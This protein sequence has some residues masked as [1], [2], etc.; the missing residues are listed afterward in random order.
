MCV[1]ACQCVLLISSWYA[2]CNTLTDVLVAVLVCLKCEQ[3]LALQSFSYALFR[4]L[5]QGL[6]LQTRALVMGIEHGFGSHENFSGTGVMAKVSY[7]LGLEKFSKSSQALCH[8]RYK[9]LDARKLPL[10]TFC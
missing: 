2:E 6:I 3:E 9:H 1:N 8:L 7:L 10:R 5:K 4:T